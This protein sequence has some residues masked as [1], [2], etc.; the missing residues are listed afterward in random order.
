MPRLI[1][2]SAFLF[3]VAGPPLLGG[4]TSA[5]QAAVAAE[6]R[7]ASIQVKGTRRYTPAEVSRLISIEIGKPATVA[8][9]TAAADR[10]SATGL[11]DSVTHGDTTARRTVNR[12]VRG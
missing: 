8:D 1:I 6:A 7:V 10:L 4:T 12:H 5:Y 3:C 2:R 11:F 9:L